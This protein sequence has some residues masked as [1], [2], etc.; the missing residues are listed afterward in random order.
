LNSGIFPRSKNPFRHAHG[1]RLPIL[2][3]QGLDFKQ[4]QYRI[5]NVSSGAGRQRL[6]EMSQSMA[7]ALNGGQCQ[8]SGFFLG[9]M[10]DDTH[11]PSLAFAEITPHLGDGGKPKHIPRSGFSLDNV[12]QPIPL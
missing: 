1:L 4:L 2:D 7:F 6:T 9:E 10:F 5:G 3:D 8:P 12:P 11:A